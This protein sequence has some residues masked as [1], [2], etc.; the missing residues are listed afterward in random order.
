[1]ILLALPSA[2]IM[3]STYRRM[4]IKGL[5]CGNLAYS[6]RLKRPAL[7]TARRHWEGRRG[8]HFG[9]QAAFR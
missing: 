5:K 3:R 8:K 9:I 4:S 2:A 7:E 6:W 1:M